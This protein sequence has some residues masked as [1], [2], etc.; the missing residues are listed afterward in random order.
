LISSPTASVTFSNLGDFAT[1]YKHLQIRIVAKDSF[2]GGG[3]GDFYLTFNGASSNF[4]DHYLVGQGISNVVS[5]SYGYTSVI[6]QGDIM[7]SSAGNANRFG[8]YVIDILDYASTTK[9]KTTRTFLGYL[10][11]GRQSVSLSS[12][13]WFS[14]SA[15]TSFNLR[16]NANIVS[17][18]RFSL[19]GI[20]G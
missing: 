14:T 9:N 19:Y 17:G 16:S 8:A 5:G 18:S 13:A 20:R 15:I 10:A 7:S 6:A 3:A 4:R 12:G 11:D 2:T 1:T